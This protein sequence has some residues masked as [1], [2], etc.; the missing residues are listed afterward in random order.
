MRSVENWKRAIASAVRKRYDEALK[1]VQE[2]VMQRH[3]IDRGTRRC[4]I[5]KNYHM[6]SVAQLANA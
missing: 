2:Y 5:Q 6:T 4:S 1:Q 3:A